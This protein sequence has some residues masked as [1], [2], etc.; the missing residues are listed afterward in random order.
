MNKFLKRIFLIKIMSLENMPEFDEMPDFNFFKN[1]IYTGLRLQENSPE[2]IELNEYLTIFNNSLKNFYDNI[3]PENFLGYFQELGNWNE[4]QQKSLEEFK[5]YYD[6]KAVP[7]ST[8]ISLCMDLY[9]NKLQDEAGQFK[10]NNQEKTLIEVINEKIGKRT[11]KTDNI[12]GY[13][14]IYE[15]VKR[16]KSEEENIDNFK[17]FIDEKVQEIYEEILKF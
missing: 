12:L 13:L 15:F 5:G 1:Y 8:C 16:H 17:S 7:K 6:M 3:D 10:L 14:K 2:K 4:K 11:H 9:I